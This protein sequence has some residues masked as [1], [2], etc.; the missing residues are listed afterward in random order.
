MKKMFKNRSIDQLSIE[1]VKRA[2][3]L[4]G[5]ELKIAIKIANHKNELAGLKHQRR[6]LVERVNTINHWIDAGEIL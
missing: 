5:I 2:K 1:Y 6:K 3:E 4:A